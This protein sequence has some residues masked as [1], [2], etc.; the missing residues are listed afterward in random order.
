VGR[1]AGSGQKIRRQKP[2]KPLL[3]GAV[4][5]RAAGLAGRFRLVGVL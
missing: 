2:A 3:S 5:G 4:S 1:F